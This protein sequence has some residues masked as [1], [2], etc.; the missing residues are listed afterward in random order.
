MESSEREI[1]LGH[2]ASRAE[3]PGP[4]DALGRRVLADYGA[5][6]VTTALA[7]PA[8]AFA[9]AED[10]ERFQANAGAASADFAGV[11]VIL[12]RPALDALLGAR[13]EARGAGFEVAP[14][15][16]DAAARSWGDSERLW[17]GRVERACEHWVALGR[18]DAGVA[19]EIVRMPHREQAD[20]VLRLER[21]EIWFSTWFDK[22]I[23]YSVA[24]PGTSQHLSMLAFD[25]DDFA[26]PAVRR[27][28]ERNGWFQTV[29]SDLPH[30]TFL[31]RA[32]AEL[33]ALGLR[34]VARI[35]NGFEHVYWVP[36]LTARPHGDT[37]APGA[38]R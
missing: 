36:D 8:V 32:E 37:A 3:L 1:F 34:P 19:A 13:D 23:L 15:G 38:E 22:S 20:A 12:Q 2:V 30:F 4:D 28:L 6:F 7:P 11:E 31:G 16:A 25:V 5:M 21:E 35:E 29:V 10:V 17:R 33:P 27:A 18:L 9:S 26:N 14:R 24:A